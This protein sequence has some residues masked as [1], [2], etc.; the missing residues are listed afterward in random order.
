MVDVLVTCL[1]HD[2]TLQHYPQVR[3]HY[4]AEHL[5]RLGVDAEFRPLPLPPGYRCRVAISAEYQSD[6]AWFEQHLATPL[7]DLG[8][9]RLYC[10]TAYTIG[11]RDHFSRPTLEWFGARGGVLAFGL[12]A[13]PAPFEHWIGLGVAA[14][15]VPAPSA[16]RTDAV[17]DVVHHRADAAVAIDGVALGRVRRRLP[18]VRLVGT[19]PRGSRLRPACDDWIAYGQPHPQYVAQ[20]FGTAFAFVPVAPESMGLVVAEAQVAGCAVVAG[21]GFLKDWI[22]CPEADVPYDPD[23]PDGLVDALIE[24]THRDPHCIASQARERFDF[25]AVARR[26]LEAIGL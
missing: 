11:S 20:L 1:A 24:A 3:G 26:T 23:D 9:E 5:A 10:L 4:L 15:V 21:R 22:V 25:S 2:G 19:G 13:P 12:E 14:D 18:G 17:F 6:L 8:A 7:T 16:V